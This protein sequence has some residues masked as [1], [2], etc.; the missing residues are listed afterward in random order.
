MITPVI[1][2]RARRDPIDTDISTEEP[3]AVIIS[4]YYLHSEILTITKDSSCPSSDGSDPRRSRLSHHYKRYS[5]SRRS[6]HAKSHGSLS[7]SR[8][9][10]SSR[11]RYRS[12]DRSGRSRRSDRDRDYSPDQSRRRNHSRYSRSEDDSSPEYDSDARR[13]SNVERS[14]DR[15][16]SRT[17]S[18]DRERDRGRRREGRY[19]D[20]GRERDRDRRNGE[21]HSDG[22]RER[23]KDRARRERDSDKDRGKHRYKRRSRSM[24]RDEDRREIKHT[25]ADR[26]ENDVKRS[27]KRLDVEVRDKTE[28]GRTG[29]VEDG[30]RAYTAAPVPITSSPKDY[31]TSCSQDDKEKKG[32]DDDVKDDSAVVENSADEGADNENGKST[33]SELMSP[34]YDDETPEKVSEILGFSSFGTTKVCDV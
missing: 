3:A 17:R 27:D 29:S 24:D 23:D 19:S 15:D 2:L 14:R 32:A 33:R 20:G 7:S 5:E 13:R 26:S 25:A 31:S 22:D 34:I 21:R 30:D 28:N 11:Y 10:Q 12:S 18:R 1:A 6:Y 9:D 16:R 4:F 8:R